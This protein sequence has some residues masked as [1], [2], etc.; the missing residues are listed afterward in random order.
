M[1]AVSH[2]SRLRDFV[3]RPPDRRE[4]PPERLGLEGELPVRA[5]CE[6]LGDDQGGDGLLRLC[7]GWGA[8]AGGGGAGAARQRVGEGGWRGAVGAGSEGRGLGGATRQLRPGE[9]E[10]EGEQAHHPP[11]RA[12]AQRARVVSATPA[13]AASANDL[14]LSL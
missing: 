14:S 6:P 9:P 3:E 4:R 7:S 1:S 8:A 11:R 5:E 12:P 13:Q 2:Q 10:W